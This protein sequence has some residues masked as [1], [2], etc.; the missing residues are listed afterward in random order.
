MSAAKETAPTVH[1]VLRLALY[2][3]V[4]G[5]MFFFY[6][7]I[8]RVAP[9]VMIDELMRDFTVGAAAVGNLSAFY[10]YGYAGMQIPVGLLMD[11]FGPRRLMTLAALGCAAGCVLFALAP[12]LWALSLGRFMIGATAAF[13]LV[14]AMTV[15]GQWFPPA[16]FALLS[17]FAMML[18]MAGGVFGQ[19]PLRLLVDRLDWRQASLALASGGVLLALA[20]VVTVRDR[21]R[22]SGSLRQV[23]AGLSRV[24]RNRQTWL[25][26]IAGLGTTGPLL[27]FAGL[28]GVPFLVLTQGI[29]RTAA[30]GVTSMV[31]IGWGVG[32]PVVGWLSDRFRRRKLPFVTGLTLTAIAMAGLAWAPGLPLWAVSVLCF[33]CG[34]GGSGQIVGFAAVR[35]LNPPAA[36]GAA[37]GIVN[38]VVTGAGA[39]YQPLLGW[40]LDLT[41]TGEMAGGVRVYTVAAYSTAFSVLVVGAFIGIA[42]ALLMRETR[43]RQ[44]A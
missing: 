34:F 12:T 21:F 41:W 16:R 10:F 19:A 36:G 22:P 43:C 2:G 24:G 23:M 40:L 44:S 27:G 4:T 18:G 26:A 3:W 9:S 6:A 25:I 13:S 37:L 8:L 11:R 15:A 38:G 35:E 14:G 20:V 42:C 32:A 5:A 29:D 31:F 30:A 7:W 28:W 39:L 17:G 1:P 33:L